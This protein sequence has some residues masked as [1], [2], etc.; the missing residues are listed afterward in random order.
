MKPALR[1]RI[2]LSAALLLALGC[3]ALAASPTPTPVPSMTPVPVPLYKQ[4]TLTSQPSQ[5]NVQPANYQLS[6]Q[7]PVLAGSAD[8]RV[9]TFNDEIQMLITKAVADYEANLSSAPASPVAANSFFDVKY[10]LVSPPGNLFSIRFETLEYV[11]GAA[12]PYQLHH[13]F[14]YDLERG[15][16]VA[17][18]DLFLSGSDFLG[19]ISKYCAAQLAS[20]DIDFKDFSQGADPTPDNYKNWNITPDGLLTTFDEYQVA[21]YAAGPQTVTVPYPLLKSMIDPKGALAGF[22]K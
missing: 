7:T 12:H 14:N 2:L 5:K 19:T 1:N 9:K 8:P 6:V 22:V 10:M 16:D 17:L 21:P 3:N 4:V 11:S 13:A 18:G 20:R 15:R